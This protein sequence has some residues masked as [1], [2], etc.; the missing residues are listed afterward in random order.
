MPSPM[1][2][3]LVCCCYLIAVTTVFITYFTNKSTFDS[4]KGISAGLW[5]VCIFFTLTVIAMI[6]GMV[7]SASESQYDVVT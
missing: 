4:N 2:L 3:G 5:L 6:I 7:M 1:V